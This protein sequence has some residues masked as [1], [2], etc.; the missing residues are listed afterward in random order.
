MTLGF[1]ACCVTLDRLANLSVSQF[2]H[3]Q[4]EIVIVYASNR[5]AVRM[6]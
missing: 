6:Y 2:S 3:Q 4:M 5:V 1:K